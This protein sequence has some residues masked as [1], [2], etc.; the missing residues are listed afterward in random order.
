[1]KKPRSL[2]EK[3]FMLELERGLAAPKKSFDDLVYTV[4]LEQ[5]RL[6]YSRHGWSKKF[7]V[8]LGSASAAA[9]LTVGVVAGV[10]YGLNAYNRNTSDSVMTGES[11]GTGAT[12]I[13]EPTA[14][15]ISVSSFDSSASSK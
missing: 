14:S 4:D 6:P 11:T 9:V 1:M 15:S 10:Y 3:A 5:Y 8:A 12:A 13:S 2:V 7:W